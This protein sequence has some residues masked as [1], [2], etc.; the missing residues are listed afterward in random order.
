MAEQE[1]IIPWH[2]GRWPQL[3]LVLR[4]AVGAS[5]RVRGPSSALLHA[6]CNDR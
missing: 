3:P 6:G 1:R 4:R 2:M 5:H